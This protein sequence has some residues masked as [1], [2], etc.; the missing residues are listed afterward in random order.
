MFSS[1]K[2]PVN[3]GEELYLR[4]EDGCLLAGE[5]RF[6]LK[7][8][9]SNLKMKWIMGYSSDAELYRLGLRV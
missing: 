2:K 8:C 4:P 9:I 6:R 7:F 5:I 1:G 3:I